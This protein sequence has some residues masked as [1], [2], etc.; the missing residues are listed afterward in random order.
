MKG[1]TYNI[2]NR[3]PDQEAN[4]LN[5]LEPDY[6]GGKTQVGPR[7]W[8][9]SFQLARVYIEKSVVFSSFTTWVGNKRR[10]YVCG[11]QHN[12]LSTRLVSIYMKKVDLG[13]VS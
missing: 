3:D 6:I 5:E 4:N 8:A 1:E 9:G 10:K 12:S 11:K 2:D 7:Y 13:Q